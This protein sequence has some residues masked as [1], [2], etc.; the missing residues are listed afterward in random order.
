MNAY[1]ANINGSNAYMYRAKKNLEALMEQ[2]GMSTLWYSFSAADNYW[3]DMQWNFDAG[4]DKI[5]P[6]NMVGE[7]AA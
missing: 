3:A 1:N 2:D 5:E 4:G 6:S 7:E